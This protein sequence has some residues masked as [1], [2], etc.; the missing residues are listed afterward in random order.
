MLSQR[1]VAAAPKLF[2][3]NFGIAAPALQNTDPIQQLF[4]D[5]I[6]EFKSKGGKVDT[7][8]YQKE[9]KSELERIAKAYG[10][11][12]GTDMT[13]FPKF[14]FPEPKVEISA[15]PATAK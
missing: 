9:L 3:R 1:I 8:E 2:R 6:R 11:S 14:N 15:A 13:S 7:P 10:G 4:I 5:K 12:E